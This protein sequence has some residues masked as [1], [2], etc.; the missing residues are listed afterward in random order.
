MEQVD[1]VVFRVGLPCCYPL[2]GDQIRAIGTHLEA[3]VAA[4]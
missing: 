3:T 2:L 1:V 4:C